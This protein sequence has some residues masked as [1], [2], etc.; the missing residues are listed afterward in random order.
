LKERSTL[1]PFSAQNFNQENFSA[2][3]KE[4]AVQ[5]REMDG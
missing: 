1:R 3:Q 4:F 2:R 5:S